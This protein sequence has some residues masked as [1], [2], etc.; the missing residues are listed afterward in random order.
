MTPANDIVTI[1]VTVE[2]DP[3]EAFTIFTERT[4][5]WWR[6]G[7]KFRVAGRNPGLL[8]FEPR[9]GG[10][11]MEQFESS[12]GLQTFTL[13]KITV[14][15]PPERFR[16][17]WRA[18]NFAP[19]ESTQVEVMFEAVPTGTRVTVRHSGW[20]AIRADHPA[21]HGKQGAEF[22]RER[23]LWWADLMTSFREFVSERQDGA[24]ANDE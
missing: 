5:L 19:G 23:G 15:D 11:L 21:R 14:W 6:R 18:T 7:P 9:E 8:R 3:A 12:S 17:E 24:E 20:A 22:I 16:F 4:D 13:G 2:A 10:R 1:S